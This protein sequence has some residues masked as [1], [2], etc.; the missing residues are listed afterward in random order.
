MFRRKHSIQYNDIV[1]ASA[2]TPPKNPG[3]ISLGYVVARS[4]F[5]ENCLLYVN[6]D[7]VAQPTGRGCGVYNTLTLTFCRRHFLL[8]KLLGSN[9]GLAP[10]WL[11]AIIW[12]ND[13]SVYWRIYVNRKCDM[14]S[15]VAVDLPL[16]I[17]LP[18]RWPCFNGI[19]LSQE[20]KM[21]FQLIHTMLTQSIF[22]SVFI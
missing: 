22:V 20:Y 6:K 16:F 11:V 13:D 4:M 15:T 17:I 19:R 2:A 5:L 9:Y 21:S 18:Y 8:L 10:N 12:T 3:V 14:C 7:P 1:Y